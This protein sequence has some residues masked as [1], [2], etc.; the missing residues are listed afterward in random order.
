MATVQ[1]QPQ[2]AAQMGAA[3]RRFLDSLTAEQKGRATFEYMDGERMYWYYPPINRHGLALRDMDANQRELAFALLASGLTSRSYEQVRQIMEHEDVLG[4]L[5]KEMGMITFVRDIELYYFT[6]FGEPGTKEPWGWRIEGHH[7]SLH[8]SI[9]ADNVISVTP[10]FFGAN[11]AEVRN[12]PKQGC[13]F[14]ATAKTWLSSSWRASTTG[15][16]PP[17]PSTARHRWTS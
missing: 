8:F 17:R 14:W 2:A 1:S 13:A 4:P 9:W 6:I 5:E 15:S 11:P 16:V 7:V 10:F 12:G 3:A